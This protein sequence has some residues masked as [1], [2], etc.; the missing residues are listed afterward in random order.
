MACR[1]VQP[2]VKRN[3]HGE[4]DS[5]TGLLLLD[6]GNLPVYANSEAIRIL[7]YPQDAEKVQSL[8]TQLAAKVR[9]LVISG[10]GST[11]LTQ[12]RELVSGRR[13]YLCRVFDL[14]I[15]WNSGTAAV[16]VLIERANQ[17]SFQVSLIAERFQLTRREAETVTLLL[18]G[19]TSKEIAQRMQISPNTVKAF[20]RLVML[21]MGVSTRPGIVGKF[22]QTQMAA[23]DLIAHHAIA[24][25]AIEL[26]CTTALRRH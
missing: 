24:Q 15:G 21:K 10:R 26:P 23:H 1:G 5:E 13:R 9:S 18:G 20:L 11:G 19:L 2:P 4:D 17:V 6:P 8:S 3:N 14:A 12:P 7:V 25:D 16:A 22:F